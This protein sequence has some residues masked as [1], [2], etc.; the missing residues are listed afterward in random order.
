MAPSNP[1]VNTTSTT[2]AS[3]VVVAVAV[4]TVVTAAASIITTFSLIDSWRSRRQ[5][6]QLTIELR[7]SQRQR[8]QHRKK[9]PI[10]TAESAVRS[11]KRVG[12]EQN[13]KGEANLM[14]FRDG[15]NVLPIGYVESCYHDIAVTPRQPGLVPSA[16]AIITLDKSVSPTT[17]EGL[18]EHSHVWIVFLFHK[19]N[20]PT[21]ILGSSG[22]TNQQLQQLR[23]KGY[24]TKIRV[25]RNTAAKGSCTA[26]NNN[27]NANCKVG[28]LATRTP[29]RPNPVGLS[30]G[31]IE[32]VCLPS[33]QITLSGSD[34]LDGTPVIDIKPYVPVYD[35]P[36]ILQQRKYNHESSLDSQDDKNNNSNSN[37]RRRRNNEEEDDGTNQVSSTTTTTLS[38]SSDA[39]SSTP[40]VRVPYFSDPKSFTRRNVTLA[41]GLEE[42]FLKMSPEKGGGG[43]TSLIRR[44]GFK[45]FRNDPPSRVLDA[46]VQTLQVDVS[47]RPNQTKPLKPYV[48]HFDGLSIEYVVSTSQQKTTTK[49]ITPNNDDDDCDDDG[50]GNE[51]PYD[52][53]I[54]SVKVLK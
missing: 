2:T 7:Q 27:S 23:H 25:P 19:N 41:D 26:N 35:N 1:N 12:N 20:N 44:K 48:L 3:V 53:H 32:N 47:R 51:L 5:V 30:L 9:H 34:L 50:S 49:E 45:V 22:Q 24:K 28:C 15:C 14:A 46:L 10:K 42:E 33:R 21:K 18:D 13:K 8:Q 17:L 36:E 52:T 43:G 11:K 16:K 31:T 37:S 6:Q 39:S 40:V 38:S 54:W 29:H 4:T